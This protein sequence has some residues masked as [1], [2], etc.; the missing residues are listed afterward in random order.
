MKYLEP[1]SVSAWIGLMYEKNNS[2]LIENLKSNNL[3]DHL[4]NQAGYF[5][6]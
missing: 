5:L 1:E 6:D 2:G 4:I 3:L